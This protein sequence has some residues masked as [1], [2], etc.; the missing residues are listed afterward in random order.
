M[1]RNSRR[2][3]TLLELLVAATIT[4]MLAGLMLTVVTNTLNLWRRNQNR[5][6]ASAQALLALDMIERDLQGALY[7]AD[8][9][10]WLAVDVVNNAAALVP[11]GWL[12]NLS[13]K[14]ATGES[15]RLIPDVDDGTT[16]LIGNA[17]FG[18]SGC[19]LRFVTTNVESGGALPIAVSYQIARRPV[20]GP[21]TASNPAEVR[22]TLF[23]SAVS[24]STTFSTGY[25]VAASDYGSA[26]VSPAASRNPKTLMNPNNADALATN[27]VDFGVWFYARD[28]ATGA[29]RRIFP[30]DNNDSTHAARAGGAVSDDNRFPDV[31][32]VMVR[33]L[34]EQGAVLLD[35]LEN[36]GGHVIRPPNYAS[37]AEWWWGIV[38]THSTVYARRIELRGGTR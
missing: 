20:S 23:R 34:S 24:T 32:D 4:L 12:T 38:E 13:M 25:D 30:S 28:D 33:I 26:S 36:G 16:P 14:P 29:L 18:L 10:T 6:T 17:R 31:A 15:G 5:F 19:W 1:R 21:I 35:E 7:R 37:D 22:Y 2:G 3:F 8:G 9:G 27:V 11:H